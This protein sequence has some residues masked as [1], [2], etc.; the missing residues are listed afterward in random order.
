M[1]NNVA[2]TANAEFK[3]VKYEA[4]QD[5]KWYPDPGDNYKIAADGTYNIYFRPNGDGGDDWHYNV[6]YAAPTYTVT[7]KNWDDTVIGT[8]TVA[9][10]ET[11]TFSDTIGEIKEKP[12]DVLYTYTFS[13]W[14]PDLTAATADAEYTATFDAVRNDLF[15]GNSI[16]LNGNIAVYYYFALTAEEAETATV[17]FTWNGQELEV[18]VA[19]DPNG[20]GCYRAACPVAVAEMTCNI[21]AVL[22]LDGVA[23]EG[24]YDYS[25]KEYA[26]IILSRDFENNYKGTGA[27]SYE[28]LARLV[29]TMLDYGAKAQE[30]FGVN[31][32]NLAN[33][34]IDYTMENVDAADVPT[35]KDSFGGTDF[36]AYGLKYYGTTVVYLSE[37]TI[38]HYF[39]VTDA[40]KF[41]AIKDSVTFDK[42]SEYRRALAEIHRARLFKTGSGVQYV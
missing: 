14:T 34:G 9:E 31:T 2:L 13:G 23:Q 7:W 18:P 3:V 22:K 38:R 6:I 16:A 41:A 1:L 28:N 4:G 21:N 37:T 10:G 29:K 26:T 12:D 36:S 20:T 32:D 19:L 33:F 25:V 24:S 17:L 42:R 8:S 27:K 15:A 5:W 39:T 30:Q 35:N 40:D 11:P